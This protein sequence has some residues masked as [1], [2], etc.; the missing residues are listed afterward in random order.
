MKEI[1]RKFR[2]EAA[3]YDELREQIFDHY[4][5][6][7]IWMVKRTYDIEQVYLGKSF[8]E[9]DD[10]IIEMRLRRRSMKN[11]GIGGEVFTLIVKREG[12]TLARTEVETN[13]TENEFNELTEGARRR[14]EKTRR[15]VHFG[16]KPT[17]HHLRPLIMEIDDYI[18]LDL[19]IIEVE[20]P[21]SELATNFDP[22]RWFGYEMTHDP[23]FRNRN[24]SLWGK[25]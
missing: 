18:G 24:I 22:P 17:G 13:V 6:T 25:E 10:G 20:F 5:W 19:L 2:P 23:R 8:P 15:L 3:N 9:A 14:V 1:E 4:D 7:P 21:T 12:P 11:G 16:E